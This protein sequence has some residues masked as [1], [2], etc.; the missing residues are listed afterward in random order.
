[1]IRCRNGS[2]HTHQ[3]V[4]QS[5]SCWNLAYSGQS[6]WAVP[7]SGSAAYSTGEK[8]TRFL[9][10][11]DEVP[12]GY[13]AVSEDDEVT[14]IR[15]SRPTAKNSKW[16]GVTVIQRVSGPDLLRWAAIYPPSQWNPERRVQ[17][18]DR[19][20]ESALMLLI[21]DYQTAAF[22][23][24]EE[25]GKCA[26]CNTRLT[27]DWRKIGIGPECVKHWPWMLEMYNERH[28]IGTEGQ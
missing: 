12:D 28:G 25:I 19:R 13:Y 2:P 24:A 14:F 18:Y 16:L 1:M 27:S 20:V 5:R 3:T 23:Y 15:V 9:P 10:L 6:L 21:V 11:I 4:E 17:V 8:I 26:R 22:R 7:P